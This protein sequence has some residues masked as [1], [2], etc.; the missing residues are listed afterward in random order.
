MLISLA[1]LEFVEEINNYIDDCNST[2]GVFIDL[3]NALDK[4]NHNILIT[5]LEHKERLICGWVVILKLEDDM[6]VLTIHFK[7]A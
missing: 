3:K 5:E 4:V 2:V 7:N 6:F 1:I